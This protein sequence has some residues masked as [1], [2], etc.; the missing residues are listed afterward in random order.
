M[1]ALPP[2]AKG[3]GGENAQL[4]A[5][6]DTWYWDDV[7]QDRY[8]QFALASAHPAHNTIIGLHSILGGSGMMAYLT[9]MAER[10]FEIWRVLGSTGTLYLHCDPTASHYLKLLL[11]S[12]FGVKH[13]R[14]EI[15]W[16]Y[17]GPSASKQNFPSKH[18]TIFRYTKGTSWTFNGDDVKV[19]Y[20]KLD[21][22]DT[23]GI[24]KQSHRLNPAGK[25]PED[26]W[27]T[28]SPVGRLKKERLGYPTQ[29]P[30]ALLRRI[31]KAS[32]N[33]GETVLDPFCG[34]GTAVVAADDLDR[35]WLGI[36]I[37]PFAIEL[38][39]SKRFSHQNV[40][41]FGVPT[42]LDSARQLARSKPLDFEKWAVTRIPGLAP[43]SKQVAD[44]GID[45]YGRI[46]NFPGRNN[47]VVAQV[48]SGK[49]NR[50]QLRDFLHTVNR[51]DAAMGIYI[52][53]GRVTSTDARAEARQVGTVKM[54]A[55]NYPKIVFWTV[56]E[57]FKNLEPRIPP[58]ADPYTGKPFHESLFSED[59]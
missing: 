25:I 15:V 53:I 59:E 14:N 43:N 54:G 21:T 34:C 12:I 39:R 8:A 50:S 51:E 44:R 29:K 31:I 47:L 20:V 27:P 48:K 37:S 9:Y 11:D 16:C 5:F 23:H 30:L 33:K 3:G 56:E 41:V 28:I 42:D 6:E 46:F 4:L 26:W 35:R 55:A 1:D 49:F 7:A 32:S 2:L 18:D 19:P 58:L 36:D 40:P 13:F 57:Y 10:L 24:F 17:T 22:G 45:G 52:T 38:V